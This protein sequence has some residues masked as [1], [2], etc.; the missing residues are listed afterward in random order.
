MR[1]LMRFRAPI[2]EDIFLHSSLMWLDH[3]SQSSIIKRNDFAFST[4]QMGWLSNWIFISLQFSARSFWRALQGYSGALLWNTRCCFRN[5]SFLH[6]RGFSPMQNPQTWRAGRLLFVW[7]LTFDLS[8]WVSYVG[9]LW[10]SLP[11]NLR[12][13]DSLGYFKRELDKF[14]SNFQSGFHT[15]IL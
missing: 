7:P 14:H 1:D 6:D 9:V 5:K 12:K 11:V 2:A 8:S 10:N 3:E 4:L 13:S 15:A